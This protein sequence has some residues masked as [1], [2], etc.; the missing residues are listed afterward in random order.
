[1]KI[2]KKVK[3]LSFFRY[4]FLILI[5]LYLSSILYCKLNPP[6]ALSMDSYISSKGYFNL[7]EPWILHY[8]ITN[9][10]KL[11]VYIT[12]IK[13]N[14]NNNVTIEHIE[15]L[16]NE[17]NSTNKFQKLPSSYKLDKKSETL[18]QV[19]M[20]V[21]NENADISSMEIEYKFLFIKFKQNIK[22]HLFSSSSV[23]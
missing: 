6:L 10:Y 20:N 18:L 12:N 16:N 4:P 23:S 17:I 13:F 3:V 22:F 11:P 2:I 8:G 19:T 7:H 14:T 9:K 5:I 21:K 15:I 1:M